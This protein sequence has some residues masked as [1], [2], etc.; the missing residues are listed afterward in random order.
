MATKQPANDGGYKPTFLGQKFRI[1]FPELTDD[2]K[3][4]LVKFDGN[5][6]RLD[7]IHYT[8]ILCK[9]R[10][11]PFFTACNIDGNNWQDNPRKGDWADDP[12]ITAADQLGQKLYNAKKSDFDRGHMVRRE[13][14]EWGTK[15]ESIRAGINT[16]WFPN[17]SPQH[18]KLNQ[19]IWAEL[20]ANI[21]HLGADE[22]NLKV[23]VFSGPVLAET[24]G[25]FVTKVD[26]KDIQIPNLFWKVVVWT[27]SNGKAYAVGFL[28]SQEKFLIEGGIIKKPMVVNTKKLSKLKDEDIFE[29]LKF[30]DGKTYQ[31]KLTEIENLT[32]LK[33]D[34]PEVLRPFKAKK[35]APITGTTVP[36]SAKKKMAAEPGMKLN[37]RLKG[38]TL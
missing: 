30:K 9:S 36:P 21:L 1:K 7:Y 25:T 19:K 3:T 15:A 34:W 22:Q 20:E 16:F 38:L 10:R 32:G 14:P 23:N 24:D 31:V 17:C 11:L 33:F 28:M 8:S 29:H 27:K 6:F 13:D 12:R 26:G 18:L 4:D 35:P 2:Q 37:V 5:K